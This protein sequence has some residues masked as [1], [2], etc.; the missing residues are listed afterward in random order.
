MS[1]ETK[2]IVVD[3]RDTNGIGRQTYAADEWDADGEGR[4]TISRQTG[5]SG[6]VTEHRIVAEYAPGQWMSVRAGDALAPVHDANAVALGIARQALR[7]ILDCYDAGHAGHDIAHTAL[8]E[9]SAE[10]G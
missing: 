1:E 3:I 8:G 9:I 5:A 4:L 6:S 2:T 7:D 10:L